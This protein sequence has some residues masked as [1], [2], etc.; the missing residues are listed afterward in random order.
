MS[1]ATELVLV[2]HG[3]ADCNVAGI[4]G[5]ERGCT[6]LSPRGR[7]QARALAAQLAADHR[8]RPFDAFYTSPRRRALET[9]A[10]VGAALLVEAHVENGL[11]PLDYGEADGRPWREINSSPQGPPQLHPDRPFA[12]GAESW[13]GFV[14]RTAAALQSILDRHP[15][16]RVLVCAHGETVEV[17]CLRICGLEAGDR[18]AVGFLTD[19]AAITRWEQHLDRSGGPLWMLA[20]HN[21]FHHLDAAADQG[22]AVEP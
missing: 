4:V 12:P 21:D 13:N 3:E 17:A 15:G 2:R 10:A 22:T 9:A 18:P 11:R 14:G 19:N 7:Q 1:V 6:G 16:Q 8:I 20:S 5:G